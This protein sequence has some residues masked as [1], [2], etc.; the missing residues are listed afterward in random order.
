[1]SVIRLVRAVHTEEEG[2]IHSEAFA[3]AYSLLFAGESPQWKEMV[4]TYR[5]G[6]LDDEKAQF[7]LIDIRIAQRWP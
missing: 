2:F 6:K 1:M 4:R 5:R 3:D 7:Y